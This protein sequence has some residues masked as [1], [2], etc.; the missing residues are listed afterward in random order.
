MP[1]KFGR[2]FIGKH[3]LFRA[4]HTEAGVRWQDNIFYLWWEFLRRHEGYRKTCERGGK[5]AFS[6]LYADFGDVHASDFKAWWN[7]GGRGVRL[8]AEPKAPVS[9]SALTDEEAL[10]LIAQGRDGRT[11]LVAIPLYFRRR[12][13]SQS[14]NRILTA[15][16]TRKRGDKRIKSSQALYPLAQ[17]FDVAGLKTT[18]KCYDLKRDNPNMPL[19]QIAQIAG[20]SRG[21]TKAEMEL[22]QTGRRGANSDKKLSMSSGASRKLKQADKLIDNVGKGVFPKAS[23]F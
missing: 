17:S 18:L 21:L 20:V 16:H 19:W 23:A 7:E 22:E 2:H 5:G 3:P 9:V 14:L 15:N 10:E 12:E 6:R 11:L 13:I 4:T 1:G 8:F